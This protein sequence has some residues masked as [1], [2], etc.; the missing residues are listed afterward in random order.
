MAASFKTIPIQ[1]HCVA[2]CIKIHSYEYFFQDH[3]DIVYFQHNG[4]TAHF[5][6][7]HI[8]LALWGPADGLR[9]VAEPHH[10]H[11]GSIQYP[12]REMVCQH[13]WFPGLQR[14]QEVATS[15]NLQR[16]WKE[17]NTGGRLHCLCKYLRSF[18]I[19]VELHQWNVQWH[20]SGRARN[21]WPTWSMH[22]DLGRE[23]WLSIK[24]REGEMLT[25]ATFSCNKT[26]QS[27]K[28]G[29]IT[30]S[31]KRNSYFWQAIA[32]CKATWSDH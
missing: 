20:T 29:K 7:T 18:D 11:V 32:A 5:P 4:R 9:G 17:K 26:L 16:C 24:W 30:N 28:V 31:S 1:Y 15:W 10:P 13:H 19:P 8:P 25:G 27:Q 14:F 2:N 3:F 21:H 22:Q 12:Q 6:T 23:V